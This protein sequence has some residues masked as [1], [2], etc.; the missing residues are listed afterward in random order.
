MWAARDTRPTC[1]WSRTARDIKDRGVTSIDRV[2][3]IFDYSTTLGGPLI[4]DRIWFHFTARYWGTRLPVADQFYNDGSQYVRHGDIL[5]VIPRLTFQATPR[6]K[7]TVM[8][9]R[10]G[11]TVGPKLEAEFPPIGCGSSS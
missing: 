8:V 1:R 11:K 6:N 3:R 5:S 10:Q 4:R 2:D 7:F 9:E